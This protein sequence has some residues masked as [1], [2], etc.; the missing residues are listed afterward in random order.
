MVQACMR[1][2]RTELYVTKEEKLFKKIC[3]EFGK[4]I[5]RHISVYGAS[6]QDY[7]PSRNPID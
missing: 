5:D 3:E 6:N 2:S 1:I 4:N 7:R